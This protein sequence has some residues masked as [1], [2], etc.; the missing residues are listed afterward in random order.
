MRLDLKTDIGVIVKFDD[1]GIVM[2]NGHAPWLADLLGR[3]D[4]RFLEKITDCFC[5]YFSVIRIRIPDISPERF[6]EAV[7]APRLRDRFK[8]AVS[9]VALDRLKIFPDRPHFIEV[10]EQLPIIT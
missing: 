9:G 4:D 10:Q 2:K 7:L 8:F 1:T 5:L 6:M 3:L